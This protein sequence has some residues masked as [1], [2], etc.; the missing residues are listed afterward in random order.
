MPASPPIV[1]FRR[2]AG[3]V[4]LFGSLG[5]VSLFSLLQAFGRLFF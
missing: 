3:A 2:L 4:L 1:P 5:F